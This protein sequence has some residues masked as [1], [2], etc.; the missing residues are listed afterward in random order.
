[1]KRQKMEKNVYH[2]TSFVGPT[3]QKPKC[4]VEKA[5]DTRTRD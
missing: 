3:V 5:A 1:M 2:G 4:S